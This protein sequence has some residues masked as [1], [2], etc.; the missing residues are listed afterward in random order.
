M[1]DR[2]SIVKIL[3]SVVGICALVSA[4]FI[5]TSHWVAPKDADNLKNPVAG[6]AA[7]A[8][9]GK[10]LYMQYCMVCHGEKG[11]GDGVAAPGLNPKPADHTSA[12]VQ[13]QTD[14]AIFW[15]MTN[16]RAP[17]AAYQNTLTETQRWDL[18]NYIR[19]LK[20]PDKGK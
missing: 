5:Q 15:K 4:T 3:L 12:A 19:T 2:S 11:R 6:N 1:S 20:K 13:A 17:M 18:V 9:A 10:Q 16:G 7:A 8:A 14:G